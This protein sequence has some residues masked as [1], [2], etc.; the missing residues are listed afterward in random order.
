MPKLQNV[1]VCVGGHPTPHLPR[2]AYEELVTEYNAHTGMGVLTDAEFFNSKIQEGSSAEIYGFMP[3]GY[4]YS[5]AHS[6]QEIV[7][8]LN[9][10][11]G[12]E[13]VTTDTVIKK[14]SVGAEFVEHQHSEE[15]NNTA[16]FVTAKIAKQIA[17]DNK[18]GEMFKDC[19]GELVGM[20]NIVY[21]IAEPLLITEVS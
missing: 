12:I 14:K 16:F 15:I 21:H 19:M 2:Q 6:L 8:T 9:M 7:D 5:S 18:S 11:D 4:Y 20:G 17:F 3:G 1:L 13:I 10:D